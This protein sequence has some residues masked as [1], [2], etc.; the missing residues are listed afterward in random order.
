MFSHDWLEVENMQKHLMSI[1]KAAVLNIA[2]LLSPLLTEAEQ[3]LGGSD[4]QNAEVRAA[5]FNVRDSPH[6]CM[7]CRKRHSVASV[8]A[9]SI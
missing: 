5:I 1:G 2:V 8:S 6:V 4:R 9:I 3:V 7:Q